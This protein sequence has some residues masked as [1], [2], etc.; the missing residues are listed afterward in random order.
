M[1][2]TKLCA[3]QSAY[4]QPF[5]TEA[6]PLNEEVGGEG[7]R[8]CNNNPTQVWNCKKRPSTT[9]PPVKDCC[10]LR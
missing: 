3:R 6:V 2:F 8:R 5:Q 7:E 9:N 1:T 10:I 4:V